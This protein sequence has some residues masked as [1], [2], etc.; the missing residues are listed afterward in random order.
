MVTKM[1]S[2]EAGVVGR[3]TSM[4]AEEGRRLRLKHFEQCLAKHVYGKA[5]RLTM[6][7]QTLGVT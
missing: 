2:G 5:D 7:L 3:I 6:G 1:W 4:Q